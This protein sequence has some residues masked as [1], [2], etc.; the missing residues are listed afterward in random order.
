MFKSMGLRA[1]AVERRLCAS[2]FCFSGVASLAISGLSGDSCTVT[3]FKAMLAWS[4]KMNSV[5]EPSAL[6]LLN[7]IQP[8]EVY[9]AQELRYEKMEKRNRSKVRRDL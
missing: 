1:L 9:I 6:L 4:W 8:A 2:C 7:F 3:L 5:L